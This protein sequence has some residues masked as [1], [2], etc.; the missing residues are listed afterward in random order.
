MSD[1]FRKPHPPRPLFRGR[2]W[3]RIGFLAPDGTITGGY[4]EN[5][6]LAALYRERLWIFL[7]DPSSPVSLVFG[8]AF[9]AAGI[10]WALPLQGRGWLESA[11][12]REIEAPLDSCWILDAAIGDR[13]NAT[14]TSR[15]HAARAP[16]RWTTCNG[17]TGCVPGSR[18]RFGGLI[19]AMRARRM[20]P[21]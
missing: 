18:T 6:E 8:P 14:A 10:G 21:Q 20:R 11:F 13:G 3:C 17:S 15:V 5:P 9:R 1:G 12:Y 19:P 2:G 16:S 7:R 4:A